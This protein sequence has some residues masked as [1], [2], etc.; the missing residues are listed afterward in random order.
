MRKVLVRRV[1]PLLGAVGFL[2]LAWGLL[3]SPVAHTAQ[4][5]KD[6]NKPDLDVPKE[7]PIKDLKAGKFVK[8]PAST[9]P[10]S[11]FYALST[12]GDFIGQGRQITYRGDKLKAKEIKG[13]VEVT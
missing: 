12:K 10:T 3:E 2:A 13:G 8:P 7:P 4:K 9:A 11:Y 1:G 5:D 6:K